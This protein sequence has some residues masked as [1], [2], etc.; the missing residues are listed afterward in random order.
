MSIHETSASTSSPEESDVIDF[1]QF[2]ES[3]KILHSETISN[4]EDGL[5]L[6]IENEKE[7]SGASYNTTEKFMIFNQALLKCDSDGNYYYEYEL[8]RWCDMINNISVES[9]SNKKFELSYY[10]GTVKYDFTKVNEVILIALQYQNAYL[11]ITFL[12]K[13]SMED[14]YEI[15][16]RHN[17]LAPEPRK[18]LA[19]SRIKTNYLKYAC[20]MCGIPANSK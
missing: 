16:I 13:P 8:Q 14:E 2:M 4:Q 9:L 6:L 17:F 7:Y 1:E 20:G 5:K 12:E 10:I 15:R 19:R 18:R 11:R 3:N